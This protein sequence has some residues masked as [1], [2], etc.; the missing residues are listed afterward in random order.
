MKSE[1]IRNICTVM[2]LMTAD[3]GIKLYIYNNLMDKSFNIIDDLV[4]FKPVI[5]T[6]LSWVNS[7]LDLGIG[8]IPQVLLNSLL[9][10][11]VLYVY[12]YYKTK[13][14]VSR[15]ICFS[16]IFFLAGAFC[17]LTDKIFWGGSLDY[18]GLKGLF[19]FD[20]KDIYLTVCEVLIIMT[21]ILYSIKN[22]HKRSS[23]KEGFKTIK[24]F[25]KFMVNDILGT[26]TQK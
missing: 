8:F 5:N 7:L 6:K 20:A 11:I 23:I 3:Q 1:R 14:Q 12:K 24:E 2:F 25:I 19:I 4:Y 13:Y 15:V 22:S 21:Y 18:I 9:I 17:S 26:R 10:F 16:Y